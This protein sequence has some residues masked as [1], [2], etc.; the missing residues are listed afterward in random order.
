MLMFVRL[1]N[2]EECVES[3]MDSRSE[4]VGVARCMYSPRKKSF[5][6]HP[7]GTVPL[8]YFGDD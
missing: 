5:S 1:K 4:I 8:G 6:D 2:D 7:G 3:W